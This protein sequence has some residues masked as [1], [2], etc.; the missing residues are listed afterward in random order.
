MNEYFTLLKAE[1]LRLFGINKALHNKDKSAKKKLGASITGIV[2]IGCIVA[3]MSAIYGFMFYESLKNTGEERYA[4][5][6]MVAV[7][8]IIVVFQALRNANG[9]VFG[10]ADYETICALPVKNKNVVW[11]KLTYVYLENLVYFILF[12]VPVSVV[13]GVLSHSGIGFYLRTAAGILLSPA[14]PVAL[15][16]AVG[17]AVAV[18]AARFKKSNVLSVILSFAFMAAYFAF[19][20]MMS[21]E[22]AEI[23]ASVATKIANVYPVADLY[24][25]GIVRFDGIK[26]LIFAG[27]SIVIFC[28][29]MSLISKFYAK[30]NRAIMYKKSG[31]GKVVEVKSSTSGKVLLKREFGKWINTPGYVLNSAMGAVML[32]IMTVLVAI[33][34]NG[35]SEIDKTV[36]SKEDYKALIAMLDYAKSFIPLVP[37]LCVGMCYYCGS[38]ISIEGKSVWIIKSLPVDPKEVFKAKIRLNLIITILPTVISCVVFGVALK[39]NIVEI[40][41]CIIASVSYCVTSAMFGLFVN[42]KKHNYDWQSAVEVIKRGAASTICVLVGMF[43]FIPLGIILACIIMVTGILG[44]PATY[45]SFVA[46][47]LIFNVFNLILGKYLSGKGVTDFLK[48]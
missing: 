37:V 9:V 39:L 46:L 47:A 3:F 12:V 36:Q 32:I 24:A 8:S 17:T 25:N 38:S 14:L 18:F 16:L 45:F 22:N 43:I 19:V 13:Y 41:L 5:A 48:S 2:I 31:G 28:L 1:S 11:A 20:F 33:K 10:F 42:I 26:F 4:P 40:I 30:I 23:I 34:L 15:G 7:T 29:Y 44:L 35:V 21:D 6:I 27:L